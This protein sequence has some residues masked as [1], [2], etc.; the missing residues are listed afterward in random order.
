M[1]TATKTGKT[2]IKIIAGTVDT[3][4][5]IITLMLVTIG[6]YALWDSKQV[7]SAADS[8]QYERYKP[9][10]ENQGLTFMELA[11]MNSD[12]FAWLTVYG[13]HI[14]YPVVQGEDNMTYVNTN[15]QGEYCLSGAIFLDYQASS[16]FSDFS[17]ILYGHH[18]EKNAMFGEIG[19]FEEKDYFDARQYGMLYY[20]GT[21]HG[22]EF[23]AFVQAD[24]YDGTI[25][26]SKIEREEDKQEY[27]DRLY[28]MALHTRN[29]QIT[30]SDRIV[31]LNTC[32][33]FST[34]GR[35]ILIGRITDEVYDD[36]FYVE[37]MDIIR[38]IFDVDG[39]LGFWNDAPGTMK[40]ALLFLPMFALMLVAALII[41]PRRKNW[42]DWPMNNKL[43]T[44]P[45]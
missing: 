4:V 1:S 34:N 41:R 30:T 45:L 21:E 12:V 23:L 42:P 39:P 33:G 19:N 18:M 15:A 11:A 13:T 35:D 3:T 40:L 7:H 29:R 26:K 14:D 25:Y 2:I 31:L 22:I 43:T 9:T 44:P 5:L 6:S 28:E 20:D 16:D 36:P 37:E 17:N 8:M 27:I 24:A 32:S 38:K 10:V